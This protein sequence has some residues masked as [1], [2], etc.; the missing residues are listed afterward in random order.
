MNYQFHTI[1]SHETVTVADILYRVTVGTNVESFSEFGTRL[2]LPM[3]KVYNLTDKEPAGTIVDCG[4]GSWSLGIDTS[5]S[6]CMEAVE[7]VGL[8][9]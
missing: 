3:F 5:F 6:E 1:T 8:T 9:T 7:A 4:K 2:D